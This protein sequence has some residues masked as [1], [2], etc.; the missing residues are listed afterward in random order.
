MKSELR[1]IYT[2]ARGDFTGETRAAADREIARVFLEKYGGYESY[3]I[4]N[5]FRS[6]AD[7]GRITAALVAAGRRVY[8][9]RVCGKDILPV[10]YGITERGAYGIEEP[11]GDVFRGDIDV[12]VVP[13]LAVNRCGFRLGYGGGY[14]DRYL[15]DRHTLAIGIGYSFQLTDA[16]FEERY[17]E[18]LSAYVSERGVTEFGR[19]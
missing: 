6:E 13:L 10:P 5:S 2:A 7:T 14:Y 4:Y 11:V 19:R 18:K 16:R 8:L 17:D 1:R 3:F 15:K 9:P 12:T